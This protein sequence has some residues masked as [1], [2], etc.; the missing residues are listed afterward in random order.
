MLSAHTN[1]HE[2]KGYANDQVRKNELP[3]KNF[4]NANT[5]TEAETTEKTVM[6][7]LLVL[8]KP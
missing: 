1:R 4:S 2:I 3:I 8:R 7:I 5:H 6:K